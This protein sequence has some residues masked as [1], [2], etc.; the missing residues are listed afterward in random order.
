MLDHLDTVVIGQNEAKK[1][2]VAATMMHL[3]R[4]G[5]HIESPEESKQESYEIHRNHVLLTGPTGVGKTLTLRTLA[6]YVKLPFIE[7]D[8]TKVVPEGYRGST[9]HDLMKDAIKNISSK[10]STSLLSHSIVFIDE[11]DKAST[12]GTNEAGWYAKIQS[13]LLK[14]LEG[15]DIGDAGVSSHRMM[16]V[17]GGN[18][19][20]FRKNKKEAT[21]KSIGFSESLVNP[22]AAEM[23]VHE[24]LAKCGILLELLGRIAV[25]GELQELTVEQYRKVVLCSGAS[26]YLDYL[27]T[28]KRIGIDATLSESEIDSIVSKA[29]K[30][31]TGLRALVSILSDHYMPRILNH[32]YSIV[33]PS[34]A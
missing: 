31:K 34:N 20:E 32:D 2:L 27:K 3:V 7:L 13:S 12:N 17:F 4:M 22:D 23:D 29:M 5:M 28:L 16:F 21:K 15:Q 10:Y 6:E 11:I 30:K 26:P 25:I 18:F 24:G 33:N 9:I 19:A 14:L 8:M 1:K